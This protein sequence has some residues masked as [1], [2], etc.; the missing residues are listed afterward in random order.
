[1]TQENTETKEP[2]ENK[3][4]QMNLKQEELMEIIQQLDEKTSITDV[5]DGCSPFLIRKMRQSKV[6]NHS[7]IITD[8]KTKFKLSLEVMA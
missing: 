1:M 8:G 5:I 7:T 3:E 2:I 4:V 6:L